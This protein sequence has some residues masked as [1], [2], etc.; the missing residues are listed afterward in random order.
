MKKNVILT[1]FAELVTAKNE[2]NTLRKL[3]QKQEF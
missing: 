3:Q 2:H 1:T